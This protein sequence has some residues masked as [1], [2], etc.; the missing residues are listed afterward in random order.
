[1]PLLENPYESPPLDILLWE[2]WIGSVFCCIAAI[3]EVIG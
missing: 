1:M 3:N 2:G